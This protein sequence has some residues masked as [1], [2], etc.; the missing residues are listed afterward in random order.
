M[1]CPKDLIRSYSKT[2]FKKQKQTN[3]TKPTNPNNSNKQGHI[4]TNI[5]QRIIYITASLWITEKKENSLY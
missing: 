3:K 5:L 4:I 1:S 2:L